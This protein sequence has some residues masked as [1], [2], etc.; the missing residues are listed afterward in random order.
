MYSEFSSSFRYL[1]FKTCNDLVVDLIRTMR[2]YKKAITINTMWKL[3]E[4]M[5]AGLAVPVSLYQLFFIPFQ[6]T[7]NF[8]LAFQVINVYKYLQSFSRDTVLN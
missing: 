1:F 6:E 2:R 4:S 7:E 3:S 5:T 8:A